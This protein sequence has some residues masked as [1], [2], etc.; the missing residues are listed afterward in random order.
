M[1]LKYTGSAYTDY[2]NED[3]LG[4]Q[5]HPTNSCLPSPSPKRRAS[6]TR[7]QRSNAVQLPPP[8]PSSHK[9]HSFTSAHRSNRRPTTAAPWNPKQNYPNFLAAGDRPANQ[10][11]LNHEQLHTKAAEQRTISDT[12]YPNNPACG[13][14][15]GSEH[16]YH[17]RTTVSDVGEERVMKTNCHSPVIE[18][19]GSKCTQ[20]GKS[21]SPT[22][23]GKSK[24]NKE[25][26]RSDTSTEPMTDSVLQQELAML[27]FEVSSS[28]LSVIHQKF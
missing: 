24:S 4:N 23:Q 14:E 8:S 15:C 12:N 10:A 9:Q 19:R 3:S 17:L 11:T 5:V 28:D 26:Q 6:T 22:R 2:K 1:C 13:T 21:N 18:R 16:S 27:R 20:S 7:S 25:F